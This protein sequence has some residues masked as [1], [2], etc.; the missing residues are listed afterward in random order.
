MVTVYNEWYT[1]KFLAEIQKLV[2]LQTTTKID[3]KILIT[4]QPK[5]MILLEIQDYCISEFML[6]MIFLLY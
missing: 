1:L 5:F 2:L 4:A 6:L 3:I